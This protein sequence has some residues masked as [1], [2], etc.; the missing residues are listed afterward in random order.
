MRVQTVEGFK[1]LN[2]FVASLEDF[3]A[4]TLAVQKRTMFGGR[5]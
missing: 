1:V 3:G 4:L 5:H 2:I